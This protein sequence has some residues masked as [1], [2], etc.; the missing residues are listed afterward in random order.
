MEIIQNPKIRSVD[1]LQLLNFK[2]GGI[3][4]FKGLTMELESCDL[5]LQSSMSV[6][7]QPLV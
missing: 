1:K 4:G 7:K 6:E 2:S 5:M 3:L